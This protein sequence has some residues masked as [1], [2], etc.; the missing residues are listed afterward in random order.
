MLSCSAI[1]SAR[2]GVSFS[3]R[4]SVVAP[5]G[6]MMIDIACGMSFTLKTAGL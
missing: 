3:Q 4:S 2:Y 1:R 6:V 5:S